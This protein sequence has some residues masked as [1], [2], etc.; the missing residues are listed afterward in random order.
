MKVRVQC[1]CEREREREFKG[2]LFFDEH[3]AAFKH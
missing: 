2:F 3:K 1:S